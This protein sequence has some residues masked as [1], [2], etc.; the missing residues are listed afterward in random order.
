MHSPPRN[1]YTFESLP[2]CIAQATAAGRSDGPP[3]PPPG[4]ALMELVARFGRI[5]ASLCCVGRSSG[6]WISVVKRAISVEDSFDAAS[7]WTNKCLVAAV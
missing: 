3:R 7:H 4:P 5:T 2:R 6:E 1:K